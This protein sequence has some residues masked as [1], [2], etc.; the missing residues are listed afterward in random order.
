[1]QLE[2]VFGDLDGR[3]FDVL[4][5]GLFKNGK[6]PLNI[7]DGPLKE[8]CRTFLQSQKFSGDW[9]ERQE[10]HTLGQL[11]TARL[12]FVGLG[13][14]ENYDVRRLWQAV[15]GAARLLN[16]AGVSHLAVALE[17]FHASELPSD[18]VARTVVEG[19]HF[20]AYEYTKFKQKEKETAARLGKLT[21]AGQAQKE[22]QRIEQAAQM[23]RIA[24]E[25]VSFARDLQNHPGNF[26]TPTRLAE[27]AVQAA[28]EVGIQVKVLE[29]PEIETEK[30]GA[31]LGVARGSQEPP[32]F[33]ILE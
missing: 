12:C 33:I 31:L 24:A 16:G 32:R 30:M 3:A 7:P 5:L 1:M 14:E 29:Q 19:V 6:G 25:S 28:N 15:S 26:L 13:E 22:R 2:C 9:G 21:L 27:I 11:P 17:S 23:G 18:V 8:F 10:V 4:L 20:G